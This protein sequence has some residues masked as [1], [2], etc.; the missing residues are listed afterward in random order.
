MIYVSFKGDRISIERDFH[1]IDDELRQQFVN[2][3]DEKSRLVEE[4]EDPGLPAVCYQWCS[5]LPMCWPGSKIG[6]QQ[7]AQRRGSAK[8]PDQLSG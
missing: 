8:A 7:R 1:I 3:R 4:A 5:Y 6:D 2:E